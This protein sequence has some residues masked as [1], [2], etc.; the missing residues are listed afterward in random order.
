MKNFIERYGFSNFDLLFVAVV[1]VIAAAIAVPALLSSRKATDEIS[2]VAA[3]RAIQAAQI[4]HRAGNKTFT[5]FDQP[6]VE[7]NNYRTAQSVNLDSTAYCAAAS[8][9]SG[10]TK[11]F[12]IDQ[13]G[14]VY[15]ASAADEITCS[16]GL[17]TIGGGAAPQH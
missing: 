7:N 16:E 1:T 2:A 5:V 4:N 11:Y 9:L 15:R 8:P 14:V 3:L 12:G 17:L 6:V 10:G 13:K